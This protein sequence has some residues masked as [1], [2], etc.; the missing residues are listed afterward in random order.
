MAAFFQDKSAWIV[1]WMETIPAEIVRGEDRQRGSCSADVQNMAAL[2]AR[3]GRS[4]LF[5]GECGLLFC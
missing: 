5:V 1:L 4:L 3:D 2:E